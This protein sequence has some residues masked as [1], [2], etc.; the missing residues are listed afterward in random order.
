MSLRKAE[1]YID[2]YM[3]K[4]GPGQFS[5]ERYCYWLIENHP[6]VAAEALAEAMRDDMNKRQW[7]KGP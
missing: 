3:P 5:Y 2:L 6:D 4:V 1:M 7:K